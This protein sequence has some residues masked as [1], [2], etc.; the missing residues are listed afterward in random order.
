MKN[1]SVP[2]VVDTACDWVR[3]IYLT[4]GDIQ[5]LD[6]QT[7]RDIAAHNRVWERNCAPSTH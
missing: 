1:G 2:A 3:P 6:R 5:A 4:A 7:K